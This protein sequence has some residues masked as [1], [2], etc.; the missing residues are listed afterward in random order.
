MILLPVD[1][2]YAFDFLAIL[3]VKSTIIGGSKV[4]A[5]LRECE[6]KLRDQVGDPL[7]SD[8]K[9][10]EEYQK[11][12]EA[13]TDVFHRIER[14]RGGADVTAKDIDDLNS[15]RFVRKKDLQSKFFNS[16]SLESKT[17]NELS[18]RK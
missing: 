6:D 13:N 5:Q 1:E 11:I 18:F 2:G 14:L 4:N 17:I 7:F 9:K 10:S 16:E 3:E 8:I 15:V 12:L